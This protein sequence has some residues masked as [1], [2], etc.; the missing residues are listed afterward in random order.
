[1]QNR[2]LIRFLT[3]VVGVGSPL[4][5]AQVASADL[6]VA[7]PA[8]TQDLTVQ[9][10]AP[11]Q[12]DLTVQPAAPDAQAAPSPQ[13]AAPTPE[14]A[15]PAPEAQP[16]PAAPTPEAAA[17]APEAQPQPAAPTPEAAAPAPEAATPTPEAAAATPAPEQ[18]PAPQPAPPTAQAA[19]DE[20]LQVAQAAAPDVEVTQASAPDVEVADQAP[21]ADDS[22]LKVADAAPQP[23][24]NVQAAPDPNATPVDATTV[25]GGTPDATATIQPAADPTAVQPASTEAGATVQPAADPTD[26]TVSHSTHIDVADHPTPAPK[27]PPVADVPAAV[28]T[29]LD[30]AVESPATTKTVRETQAAK[31]AHNLR[32]ADTEPRTR[33]DAGSGLGRFGREKPL[34]KLGGKITD[35]GGFAVNV[36]DDLSKGK[37]VP[38]AVGDGGARFLG[39]T[40]GAAAAAT[41]CIAVGAPTAGIA[42]VPC[43]L[44]VTITA[45]GGDYVGGE[46][47]RRVVDHKPGTGG[48]SRSWSP[49]LEDPT[50]NFRFYRGLFSR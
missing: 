35:V 26:D 27:L 42:A 32:A 24:L 4:F 15:A 12:A 25:Q 8:P 18:T 45:I 22:Q 40:G 2:R 31:D 14:A 33:S 44:L 34:L 41:A 11:P 23:D 19:P 16:Q 5:A 37:S 29:T 36:G 10:P 9:S 38:Y 48:S 6:Q 28:D 3:A 17:P 30:V 1:M 47:Y 49:P 21:P 13:Q 43:A 50:V 39:S 46:A 20:N 7:A